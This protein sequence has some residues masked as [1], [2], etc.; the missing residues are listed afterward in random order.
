MLTSRGVAPKFTPE[1]RFGGGVPVEVRAIPLNADGK[2]LHPK[3][4][5]GE[6]LSGWDSSDIEF[7]QR[8]AKNNP[9]TWEIVTATK[10][11]KSIVE[12]A[13]DKAKAVVKGKPKGDAPK[14]EVPEKTEEKPKE[15]DEK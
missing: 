8:K 4:R 15:G 2:P 1:Y 13:V 12:K 3:G 11:A 14:E 6:S 7:F 10:A 5:K 9:E